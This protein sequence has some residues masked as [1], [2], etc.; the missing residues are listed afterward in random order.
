MAYNLPLKY[1]PQPMA[2]WTAGLKYLLSLYFTRLY[3]I[4]LKEP[5]ALRFPG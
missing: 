4:G 5:V 1:W 2:P 3:E